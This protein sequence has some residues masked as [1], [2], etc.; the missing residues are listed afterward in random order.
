LDLRG[1]L[2]ERSSVPRIPLPPA[3]AL[4]TRGPG[5]EET[6]Q[7]KEDGEGERDQRKHRHNKLPQEKGVSKK[8]AIKPTP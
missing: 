5:E 7:T 2:S 6:E 4:L 3:L 8:R 1:F